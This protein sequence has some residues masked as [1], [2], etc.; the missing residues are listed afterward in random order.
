MKF[1]HHARDH[2][3]GV[4]DVV[5]VARRLWA[6]LTDESVSNDPRQLLER[7]RERQCKGWRSP[8]E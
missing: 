1:V 5:D 2:S 8:L 6:L 4:P 3:Y 7:F